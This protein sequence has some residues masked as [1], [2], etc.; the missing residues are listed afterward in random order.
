MYTSVEI[1]INLKQNKK[2]SNQLLN[3]AGTFALFTIM[4]AHFKRLD[5]RRNY[6]KSH[7]INANS[8]YIILDEGILVESIYKEMVPEFGHKF[9]KFYSARELNFGWSY[10]VGMVGVLLS[11]TTS[12]MWILLA[13]IL[14]YN[15]IAI[16]L[17]KYTIYIKYT[18]TQK[19]TIFFRFLHYQKYISNYK[20]ISTF[21]S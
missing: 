11:V 4:I 8:R 7:G 1:N 15:P 9:N 18:T 6:L 2:K 5:C 3:F 12:M 10:D 20:S 13:K 17:W 16:Q 21:N 19:L 14:R